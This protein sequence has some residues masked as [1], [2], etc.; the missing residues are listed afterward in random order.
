MLWPV[1]QAKQVAKNEPYIR[2]LKETSQ[3]LD[4][5]QNFSEC[6]HVVGQQNRGTCFAR[7][8][9]LGHIREV[10]DIRT[11]CLQNAGKVLLVSLFLNTVG[12][13]VAYLRSTCGERLK[14]RS[15]RTLALRST[16]AGRLKGRPK[17][18]HRSRRSTFAQVVQ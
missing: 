6:K 18:N 13:A 11:N 1:L 5:Y 9:R 15:R 8:L 10:R 14:V 17:W 7:V 2:S 3:S 16:F 4:R 12:K